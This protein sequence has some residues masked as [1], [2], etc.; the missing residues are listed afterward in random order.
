MTQITLY[1]SHHTAVDHHPKRVRDTQTG[2]EEETKHSETPNHP[3]TIG[4]L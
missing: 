2:Q 3:A 1:R 4:E